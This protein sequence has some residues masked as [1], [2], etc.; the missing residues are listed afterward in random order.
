MI[1]RLGT[2]RFTALA[3]LVSTTATFGHYF[4]TQPLSSLIQP[5]PVY[6]Y[7]LAMGIFSTVVPV[8]A[9]SAAIRRVGSGE[10]A[11]IGMVGPLLT[12]FF[13]W[14]L[15]GEGFSGAQMLGTVLVI[16]GIA[17]VSRREGKAATT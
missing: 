11:L 13:A 10:A 5:W 17:I 4:A 14:L 16:A 12:I 15:L 6:G 2:A 9:Q 1:H 7:G 8:F 3:M